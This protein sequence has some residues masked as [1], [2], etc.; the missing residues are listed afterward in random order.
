[1]VIKIT[2]KEIGEK[3]YKICINQGYDPKEYANTLA[4]IN[5]TGVLFDNFTKE[6]ISEHAPEE[7]LFYADHKINILRGFGDAARK[8]GDNE[9]ADYVSELIR[10]LVF[11]KMEDW[12]GLETDTKR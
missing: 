6:F 1:M 4:G 5:E 8:A 3:S 2:V 9:T 10:K 7:A 11:E 12:S